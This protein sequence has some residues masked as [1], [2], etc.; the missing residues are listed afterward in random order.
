M[1]WI[2]VNGVL[3]KETGQYITFCPCEK[4]ACGVQASFFSSHKAH[5]FQW[6]VENGF[7]S[8][9]HWMHF[10]PPP[11]DLQPRDLTVEDLSLIYKAALAGMFLRTGMD[12]ELFDK[13]HKDLKTA[14]KSIRPDL[15]FDKLELWN[16]LP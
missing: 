11:Q 15:D 13:L 2:S 9:T 16:K 8:P 3:P 12:Q 4:Y 1:N 14:A 7:T 10:P 5:G 6:S